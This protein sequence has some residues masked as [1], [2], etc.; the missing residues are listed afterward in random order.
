MSLHRSAQRPQI[1]AIRANADGTPSAAGSKRQDLVKTIQE[2][3]E[4][5][6]LD[7]P[8]DL[9]AV[10]SELGLGQP[11][12]KVGGG[13]LFVGGIGIDGVEGG[14]GLGEEGHWILVKGVR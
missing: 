1:H 3:G 7:E 13:L 11:A 9:R 4:L 8:F 14:E 6:G 10:R 2:T 5:L 12:L